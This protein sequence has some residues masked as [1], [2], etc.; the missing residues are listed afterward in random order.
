MVSFE[1]ITNHISGLASFEAPFRVLSS[2]GRAGR[3]YAAIDPGTDATDIGAIVFGIGVSG[4]LGKWES[5]W[6]WSSGEKRRSQKWRLLTISPGRGQRM[7]WLVHWERSLVD[8][9]ILGHLYSDQ[10]ALLSNEH[11]EMMLSEG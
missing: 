10:C 6:V 3:A 7:M 8:L 9:C 5:A 4:A 1:S 11:F 2:R